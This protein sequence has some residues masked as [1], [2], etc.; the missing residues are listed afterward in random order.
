MSASR[1]SGRQRPAIRTMA[2]RESVRVRKVA[3]GAMAA[4]IVVCGAAA[5]GAASIPTANPYLIVRGAG[6]TG[7]QV[8]RY[9]VSRAHDT[10]RDP[11]LSLAAEI[12]ALGQPS[13]CRPEDHPPT[14]EIA[15]VEWKSLHL[16]SQQSPGQL[17]P[18]RDPC[19]VDPSRVWVSSF[20]FEGPSAWHTNRGIRVGSSATLFHKRYPEAYMGAGWWGVG[21]VPLPSFHVT[22]GSDPAMR[23][24]IQGGHVRE[25][26]VIIQG[27]ER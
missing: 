5:A 19:S 1:R 4:I 2:R 20:E 27:A 3:A 26:E 13:S 6:P 15:F 9:R 21:N 12:R 16:R 22:P 17:T 10:V 18:Y 7:F 24:G 23:F 8:G 14:L 25:I 11:A